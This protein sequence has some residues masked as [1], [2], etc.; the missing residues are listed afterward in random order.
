VPEEAADWI[1]VAVAARLLG[2]QSHSVYRL[3][4]NGDLRAEQGPPT[5]WKSNGQVGERRFYRLRR[6]DVDD[7]IAASRVRPGE[8]R[9]LLN[10][11]VAAPEISVAKIRRACRDHIPPSV[12][13]APRSAV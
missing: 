7:F 12:R 4:A 8:L 10:P 9:Q 11:V 1:T 3:I 5:L 2:L 13:I 6:R